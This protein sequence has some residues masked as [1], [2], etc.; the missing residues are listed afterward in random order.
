MFAVDACSER[1]SSYAFT[2]IEDRIA[3]LAS[4]VCARTCALVIGGVTA[5]AG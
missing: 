4:V 2:V 5:E 3:E 1:S